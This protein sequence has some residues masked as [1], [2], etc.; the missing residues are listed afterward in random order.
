MMKA[1]VAPPLAITSVAF[2]AVPE[3][4]ITDWKFPPLS[5]AE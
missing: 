3:T 4:V 5:G 1:W 2:T